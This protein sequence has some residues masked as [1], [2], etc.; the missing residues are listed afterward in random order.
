MN[1]KFSDSCS[2]VSSISDEFESSGGIFMEICAISIALSE[3]EVKFHCLWLAWDD[4]AII[5]RHD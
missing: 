1:A 4:H 3:Q 5:L 2:D